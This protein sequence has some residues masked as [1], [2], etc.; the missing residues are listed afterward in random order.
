MLFSRPIRLTCF[1]NVFGGNPFF[2][3][4]A[5][6]SY[7]LMCSIDTCCFWTSSLTVRY[8]N[9]MCFAPLE[10]LSFLEKNTAAEL[11]QYI[12]SGLETES[13]IPSPEIKFRNHNSWT[14]VS[15]H[16]TNSASIVDEAMIVCFALFYYIAPPTNMNK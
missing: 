6:I 12:L 13:T 15:K 4:S 11:S 5:T 10:Y 1:L 14:M 7:V 8:F 16:A 3:G 2:N 9:S